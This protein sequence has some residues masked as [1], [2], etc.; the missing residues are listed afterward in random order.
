ML[1]F[2]R[3]VVRLLIIYGFDVAVQIVEWPRVFFLRLIDYS[4]LIKTLEQSGTT[5]LALV[6]PH[7][8]QLLEFA[9]RHLVRGLIDNGYTV[10]V[11]M[12]DHSKATWLKQEFPQVHLAQRKK[13]ARFRCVERISC[14]V[15]R[16]RSTTL[17]NRKTRPR[18]R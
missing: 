3:R 14:C 18:Q 16:Q 17:H 11:L 2:I 12:H 6:A 8:T 13:R 7:P 15:V 10:V 1:R 9:M 5:R 4:S